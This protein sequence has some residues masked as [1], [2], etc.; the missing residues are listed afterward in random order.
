MKH[1]TLTRDPSTDEGT[2]G[3]IV[4][5]GETLHTI[6]LPW[7]DNKP[8]ESCIP[9]GVYRCEIVQSPRFGRVYGLKD[10]PGRSHILIHAA[11]YGGDVSKGY[12]SDLLGC[13]APC[14]AFGRLNGQMAGLNSRAAL[15]DLMAWAGG[16]P[17]ELEIR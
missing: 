10:V 2:F 12:R 3:S 8:R 17:F 16:Q 11:N 9:V 7:R 5:D 1:A 13:I 4:F 14:M 15:G 6:E